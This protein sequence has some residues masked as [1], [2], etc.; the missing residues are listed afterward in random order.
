MFI[1]FFPENRI[2]HF[3]PVVSSL[4]E[5]SKPIFWENQEEYYKMSSAEIFTQNAY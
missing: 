3:M 2:R 5:M 1:L 4:H